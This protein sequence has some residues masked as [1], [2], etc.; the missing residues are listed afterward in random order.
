MQLIEQPIKTLSRNQLIY[1]IT[2]LISVM[3][4]GWMHIAAWELRIF[5]EL[6][7]AS[8]FIVENMDILPSV[9]FHYAYTVSMFYV[10]VCFVLP[11][12]S[13]RWNWHVVWKMPLALLLE[14]LVVC[15]LIMGVSLASG[16]LEF[17]YK[18]NES[19]SVEIANLKAVLAP[20]MNYIPFSILYYVLIRLFNLALKSL[21]EERLLR[22][23][24]GTLKRDLWQAELNPHLLF[25][26][27]TSIRG[28]IDEKKSRAIMSQAIS[29]VRYYVHVEGKMVPLSEE[30]ENCER[31]IA[32][33][34]FRYGEACFLE[35][36]TSGDLS[37][38]RILPM[39]I[40]LLVENIFKY[41]DFRSEEQPALVTICYQ[42]NNLTVRAVNKIADYTACE[43][44]KKGLRNLQE[45]LHAYYR[46][47]GKLT[48]GRSG[49]TFISTVKIENVKPY[50]C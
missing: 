11:L 2:F 5:L 39:A 22:K 29:L 49:D 28:L 6:S 10:S 1:W 9:L 40:L 21:K 3:K 15:G 37:T 47:E 44:T 4:N 35:F 8:Y 27:L 34:K 17:N 38:L 48:Y 16:A 42:N 25:N 20:F 30:I 31:L 32:I 26:L 43:S 41:G 50:D 18:P 12:V 45:R 13:K 24:T 46:E 14:F 23:M 7:L 19:W 36:S 33:N